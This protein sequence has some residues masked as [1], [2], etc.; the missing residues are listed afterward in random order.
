MALL[1]QIDQDLTGAMK[2]KDE[3]KISTLRM[4]KSAIHNWEIASQKEP[5]DADISAVLQKEIKSRKD[6]IEMYQKGGREELAQKEQAEIAILKKYLPAQM[7]EEEIRTKVKEIIV[8]VGATG[9][10]DM[11][12]VM[13]PLMGELKGQ[14][15]GATVSKIVKEELS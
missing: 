1:Q 8:K 12:Q 10:Q 15:D 3:V 4:L 6:S 13:G 2:A 5:Q 9:V 11:G 14:A 7:S